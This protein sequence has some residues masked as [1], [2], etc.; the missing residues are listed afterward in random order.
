[1]DYLSIE[2]HSLGSLTVVKSAF[3]SNLVIDGPGSVESA[4]YSGL[5]ATKARIRDHA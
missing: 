1:M 2:L 5:F 4:E 3:E